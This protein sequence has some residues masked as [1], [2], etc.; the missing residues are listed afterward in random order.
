MVT[1]ILLG[2]AA[3]LVT[4]AVRWIDKKLVGTK[5]EGRGAFLLAFSIS[6]VIAAFKVTIFDRVPPLADAMRSAWLT[7]GAIFALS[8]VWFQ[9]I[10]KTFG[11]RTE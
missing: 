1:T 3:S 11:F 2:I 10:A 8:Q 6:F 5:L 4:E 9:L 7:F